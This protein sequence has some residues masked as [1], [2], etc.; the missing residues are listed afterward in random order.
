[1]YPCKKKKIITAENE[2]DLPKYILACLSIWDSS[3]SF[4]TRTKTDLSRDFLEQHALW[5]KSSNEIENPQNKTP[6]LKSCS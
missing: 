6:N 3:F 1:M 5:G 2:F 4:L